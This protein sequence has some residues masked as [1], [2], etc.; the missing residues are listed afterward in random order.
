MKPVFCFSAP[1]CYCTQVF[2]IPHS[3][4]RKFLPVPGRLIVLQLL[5]SFLDEYHLCC[6]PGQ[7]LKPLQFLAAQAIWFVLPSKKL[8][9]CYH[10]NLQKALS[11]QNKME[12]LFAKLFSSY[13]S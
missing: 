9:N 4:F 12:I 10:R 11:E 2:Y 3:S 6:P 1:A 13:L 7:L 8:K 5:S